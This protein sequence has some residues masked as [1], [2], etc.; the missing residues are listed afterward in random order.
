MP[1][2]PEQWTVIGILIAIGAAGLAQ[3]WVFG[4]VYKKNDADW[5]IRYDEMRDDRDFWRDNSFQ[6]MSIND[7]AI[8]VAKKARGA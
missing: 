8:D 5:Q 2:T 3:Q 7:K 4:W 1:L 6:L